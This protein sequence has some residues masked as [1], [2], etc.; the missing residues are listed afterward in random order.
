MDE[1]SCD[2]FLPYAGAG[3]N[4]LLFWNLLTAKTSEHL[5]NVEPRKLIT[6]YK[7]ERWGLWGPTRAAGQRGKGQGG[8]A[9]QPTLHP[10]ARHG[11]EAGTLQQ[12]L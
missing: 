7:G 2:L 5:R 4:N 6:F 1:R 3:S 8:A 11:S 12:H 10:E 9:P